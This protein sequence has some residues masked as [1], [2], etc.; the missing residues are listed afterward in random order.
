MKNHTKL[1]SLLFVAAALATTGCQKEKRSES[2]ATSGGENKPATPTPTQGEPAA[3]RPAQ[4]AAQPPADEVRKPTAEDYATY[5][6]D[7]P[8][9]GPI[10]ATISTTMGDLHC[11]LY[12]DKVPMTVANFIGLGRGLHTWKHPRT[13]VVEK[14]KPFYDGIIFHRV[15]PGFMSQTGDPLGLGMGGPGYKFGDEFDPT[16]RHDKP[17][18]LSMANSGP[19]TNGSQFFITEVPTPHLDNR[20]TVFGHCAE[21]DLVKKINNVE[22]DPTDPS[23]SRPKET[24][25]IKTITFARGK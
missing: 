11:E 24:I 7:I 10:I 8:G 12:G 23:G 4:P 25:S 1:V 2:G 21:G 20:H 6:K 18:T 22:K 17:G 5:T 19:G 16:L 13:G 15:I 3:A 14:N 9:E